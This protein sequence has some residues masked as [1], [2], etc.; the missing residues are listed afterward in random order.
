MAE[1]WPVL[2][3]EKSSGLRALMSADTH[4]C[5]ELFGVFYSLNTPPSHTLNLS[6]FIYFHTLPF[7]GRHSCRT[8]ASVG[9]EGKCGGKAWVIKTHTCMHTLSTALFLLSYL[10]HTCFKALWV[11]SHVDCERGILIRLKYVST[12]KPFQALSIQWV[13][14]LEWPKKPLRASSLHN[15]ILNV[16]SIRL[17]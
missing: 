13:V 11:T 8:Q 4:P 7:C 3:G 10:I 2:M 9:L 14:S 12:T 17:A 16:V 5:K 15:R 1:A 6:L